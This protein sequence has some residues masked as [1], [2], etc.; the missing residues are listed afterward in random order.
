VKRLRALLYRAFL[1]QR[2]R[3]LAFVILAALCGVNWLSDTPPVH[4][5]PEVRG[6]RAAQ[7]LQVPF[8]AMRQVLFDSYL[9]AFPRVR[10]AQ[11]VAVVGI[12]E[13]SLKAQGQWPWPRDKVAELIDA[14]A[15]LQPAAIGLDVYMPEADQTSPD[16]V[17][18]NLP[19]G[20]EGA[21]QALKQLPSHDDRLAKSLRAAP[22]VL[23][24]AGFDFETLTTK[25]GLRT[26]PL[27][28]SGADPLPFVRRYPQVLASLPQLQAA[29]H[30]QGVAS[31]EADE[32]IV[33]RVPVVVAVGNQMVP[34]LAMEMLRVGSGSSAVEV[35]T[36]RHGVDKVST[37][38]LTVPTQP[39]GDVWLHFAP[40]QQS[41]QR[42]LS[43]AD[44]LA[45]KVD[46]DAI[47][48]KLVLI[49]LTGSGLNDMRITALRE[50]VP[51]VEIQA[52]ILESFF[53]HH[54]LLRPW[55][56][57]D[58]EA[59]LFMALGTLI[60][61]LVPKA[62]ARFTRQGGGEPNGAGW[63]VLGAA[64]TVFSAGYLLFWQW[65]LL[66][67]STGMLVGCAFLMTNLVFSSLLEIETENRDLAHEQQ[68]LLEEQARVSGELAAARRIQLASLPDGANAFPG[69]Q[70][71]ELAAMLEP[72]RESGGDL[73]DFFLVNE[74]QLCFA[75]GD[76]S[77][78]G[79]PAAV[80]MAMAKALAKSLA[81]RMAEEGPAAVVAAVN[82]DLSRENGEMLFITLL[83]GLLDLR[84][85]A[86]Q[87][88]NAGHDMP[89]RL[90]RHEAAIQI[91]APPQDHGPPLCVVE[92]YAYT[93]QHLQLQAGD[94]L[95]MVTDGV[96]EA[97]NAQGELYS[98]S[99]LQVAL[100][101]VGPNDS[102][103]AAVKQL[104]RDV[105]AFVQGAEASD[106]LTILVLRWNGL[107]TAG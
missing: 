4:G 43:A 34:S 25:S 82:E 18:A 57:R 54:F 106:D 101:R 47:A 35:S 93:T 89:W 85:G 103:T 50:V 105:A 24:V 95:C 20:N 28:L 11:P 76:V 19:P 68:Q 7:A 26:V 69:E 83:L 66:F 81:L 30:G 92:H 49:G 12:D 94:R 70:R 22:T 31:F 33:R 62:R 45:G 37:A 44:V 14:I 60:I 77:G 9:H 21:A 84:T 5:Q 40:R 104:R 1:Y 53:D 52:Q 73:Y 96:T 99:R 15:R 79:M 48:N 55:W 51:G 32:S 102:A 86:L 16:Q 100:T 56:M 8:T 6:N 88:V 63:L 36:G 42:G 87:L 27:Q 78:K 64:V 91:A 90:G 29:A 67:D 3:A 2:G 41:A 97:M 71:F 59:A 65:G 75:I 74:H 38:D 39:Q 98:A 46:A 13:A 58:V 17:A 10:E 23:G 107:D 72:A 61:W 80:F